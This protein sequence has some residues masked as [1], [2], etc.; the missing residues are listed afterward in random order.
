VASYSVVGTA[1]NQVLVACPGRARGKG[2][3]LRELK[4]DFKS[5]HPIDV[6][7]ATVTKTTIVDRDS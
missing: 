5:R 7:G 6:I 1:R 3:S 2:C 4:R